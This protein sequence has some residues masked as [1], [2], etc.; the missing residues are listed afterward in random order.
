MLPPQ[1]A[2]RKVH[3]STGSFPFPLAQRTL[4]VLLFPYWEICTHNNLIRDPLYTLGR[5]DFVT[6]RIQWS[7]VQFSNPQN[8]K[9]VNA[10]L[11]FPFEIFPITISALAMSNNSP[12]R[13]LNPN[14]SILRYTRAVDFSTVL[15][16]HRHFRLRGIA[17]P[18]E[19][20]PGLYLP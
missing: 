2:G 17:N 7:S 3:I 19:K 5:S 10:D 8:P 18:N 1:P 4:T 13:L 12:S 11:S 15:S 14:M 16:L 9:P 20:F 6:L